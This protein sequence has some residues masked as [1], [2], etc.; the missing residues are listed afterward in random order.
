MLKKFTSQ[1]HRSYF[2]KE[3]IDGFHTNFQCSKKGINKVERV[4]LKQIFLK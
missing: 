3:T 1:Q 2:S 4:N